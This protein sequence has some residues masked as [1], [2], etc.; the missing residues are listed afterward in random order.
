M[1]CKRSSCSLEGRRGGRLLKLSERRQIEGVNK[2]ERLLVFWPERI[3]FV[4]TREPRARRTMNVGEKDT[5][6]ERKV[7]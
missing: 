7:K 6:G 3:C 5:K 1:T 4:L 2:G